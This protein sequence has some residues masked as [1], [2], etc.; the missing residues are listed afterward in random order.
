MKLTHSGD[1]TEK[2]G[3]V[4][5]LAMK[6]RQRKGLKREYRDREEGGRTPSSFTLTILHG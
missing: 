5:E 1:A 2:G 6:I 3:K 4:N